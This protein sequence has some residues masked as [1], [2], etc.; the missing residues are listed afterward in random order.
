MAKKYAGRTSQ[1]ADKNNTYLQVR[2][3]STIRKD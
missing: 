1:R 3:M 2:A